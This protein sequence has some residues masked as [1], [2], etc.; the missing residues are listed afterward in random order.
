LNST[1]YTTSV[2]ATKQKHWN[3]QDGPDMQLPCG[4]TADS[5]AR[6][7]RE[8]RKGSEESTDKPGDVADASHQ[9]IDDCHHLAVM[10]R[11][12]VFTEYGKK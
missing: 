9:E 7:P 6:T 11:D 12:Y 2:V 3:T 5:E 8:P 4:L 10:A 1:L